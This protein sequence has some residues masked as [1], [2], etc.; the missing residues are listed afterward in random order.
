MKQFF[1]ALFSFVSLLSLAQKQTYLL[2]GTYTAGK[3]KGIHVYRFNSGNGEASLVDSAVT[4]NPS[5]LAVSPN[6]DFVYAVNEQSSGKVTAFRFN[7]ANGHLTE[8]NQQSSMGADPCYITVANNGKWV[9]VGNYSSGTLA[10]LPVQADGSLGAAVTEVQHRGSSVHARQ[11]SPHVHATVLSEN[12]RFLYVPD[13]GKDKLMI[14]AF[15]DQ[16]GSLTPK[17][18]TLKLADASGPRHFIFHPNGRWGYLV[19]ELSGNVT[20]FQY[21]NGD[22]KPFQT[23]SALPKGFTKP[24]SGADIHVSADGRFLYASL[25]DEANTLAIFSINKATGGL[26]LIGHQ[27]T[28]GKTPR[29][30]NFDPTGNYLLAANQNSDDIVVFKV[31]KKTGKLKDTGIKIDVGNPVC[32]KWITQ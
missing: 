16:T 24:F 12:N 11:Q 19:Q 7:V 10:V 18:T 21:N 17:D 29:N 9:V 25:R 14:Y 20:A 32:I 27:S 28:L 13:L 5:Y 2:V 8:L 6:E 15:N 3:S 30:F 23:I 1:T 4:A 22:L 26:R 31:N